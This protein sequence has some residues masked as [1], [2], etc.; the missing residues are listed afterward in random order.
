MR[1]V[2]T[3]QSRSPPHAHAVPKANPAPQPTPKPAPQTR[4]TPQRSYLLDALDAGAEAVNA[5][6]ALLAR[7]RPS[8]A[9][10][11]RARAA[12]LPLRQ[13]LQTFGQVVALWR[14]AVAHAAALEFGA[15]ADLIPQMHAMADAFYSICEEVGA[16]GGSLWEGWGVGRGA[17][18]AWWSVCPFRESG[19]LLG[20]GFGGGA[21]GRPPVSTRPAGFG[22]GWGRWGGATCGGVGAASMGRPRRFIDCAPT[23]Q[24]PPPASVIA[25]PPP[26]NRTRQV[27]DHLHPKRCAE[28]APISA[29]LLQAMLAGS[30]LAVA[31]TLLLTCGPS[32]KKSKKG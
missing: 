21:G 15:A 12:A 6:I 7:E 1:G 18:A 4:P 32:R 30:G 25:F 26:K 22:A 14:A 5:G 16:G 23:L 31:I 28:A 3:T 10:F 9:S 19:P 11:A 13:A 27:S 17:L 8:D 29:S 20:K 2:S 24:T